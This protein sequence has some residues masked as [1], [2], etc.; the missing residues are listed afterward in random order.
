MKAASCSPSH[1]SISI[2]ESIA[3]T[4]FARFLPMISKAAPCTGSKRD[5]HFL[6]GSREDEGAIPIDPHRPA[7][8]SDKMLQSIR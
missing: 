6:V 4:G 7:A 1:L 2:A 3:A 5:G 8:R